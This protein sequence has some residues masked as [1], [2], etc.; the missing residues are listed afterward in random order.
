[1]KELKTKS[2]REVKEWGSMIDRFNGKGNL[3]PHEGM[4]S[5][6]RGNMFSNACTQYRPC[7]SGEVPIVDTLYSYDILKSTK[8]RFADNDYI[9]CKSIKKYIGGV[10][11]GV[12]SHILYDPT[13]EM[14]HFVEYHEY[15]ETGAGYG[16]KMID[17]LENY[18]EGDTIPKGETMVR[19]NSYGDDMEYK[20]GVNALSVLS[21]D[22]KSVEDAGLISESLAEKFAGW[23][24]N[25]HE[26]II[27]IDND[28]LKNVY[29]NENIYKP[30]PSV[31]EDIEDEIL[32]AISKQR[33][34]Y[35]R[36]K[37]NYGT[38]CVNKTDRKIF[39]RGKVVDIICR[40]KMGETCQNTYLAALIRATREY[41][42]EVLE[43]L[44]HYYENDEEAT[45]S[46]DYIDRFN[47]YKTIYDK[48]GGFKYKKILSKKA[49]VLKIV[50]VD[51]EVPKE[52]QKITGRC[53]NKFT[54]SDTFKTGKYYTKEY[55][56][57]EYLGNCLAL[58]NR[59]I[60]EVPM[61]M[62]QTHLSMLIKRAVE[63]KLKPDEEL[64][65]IILTVLSMMDKSLYEAYKEEL[66][67]DEGWAEFKKDP[68]IYWYQS[69]Y[70]SGTTIKTCYEAR[71][72]LNSVGITVKRTAVYM[73]TSH[74][75]RYLGDVFVAKLF[76]TPLKQVAGTQL[77]LRAK[78]S[79]DTRGLVLRTQEGRIRN[80]PVRKSSLVADVQANTLHPD[81]LKYINSIT[82]QES[83]QNANALLM[84]MGV[85]LV[86]PNYIED[87]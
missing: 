31:G 5:K 10:Y 56:N 75:E 61:E 77:S 7:E 22:I 63:L 58:F 85:E 74:E 65:E 53:G 8:N 24:Y 46:Y 11:C 14:Y 33:G 64:K 80:T 17:D 59:A 78:G 29:G 6:N 57:I 26:E 13:K 4:V 35:Q 23:A 69:T 19:T 84:A 18:K 28:I 9:L 54:V 83:I 82:E 66:E 39:S 15:E 47:L 1:M 38:K 25:V 76:I 43:A 36:I 3:I 49:V 30:F 67:T 55:G 37:M 86:N 62:Y 87:K 68:T 71:N 27:D 40:Q 70:H 50:T 81:D 2:Y 45:F 12:T 42:M 34:E 16:V 79:Y 48:Q 73:E 44:R 41:E 60:M 52:G 20:W 21:I 51:R 72:Y 32:F